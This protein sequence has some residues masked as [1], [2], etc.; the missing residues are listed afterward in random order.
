MEVQGR[1]IRE[2]KEIKVIQI[3][4][5]EVKLLVF[6]DDKI[7]YIKTLKTPPKNY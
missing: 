3:G 7:L 6:A 2:E 1:E 4:R 5:K